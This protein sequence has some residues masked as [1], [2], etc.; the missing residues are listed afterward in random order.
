MSFDDLNILS[1]NEIIEFLKEANRF[2]SPSKNDIV[3]FKYR[4]TQDKL[5]SQYDKL[6]ALDTSQKL[7][8]N[9]DELAKKF[10][11]SEDS[12]QKLKLFNSRTEL[13]KKLKL[14][15]NEITAIE[16]KMQENQEWFEKN[17]C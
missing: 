1:K 5:L 11:E 14:E 7:A 17:S 13:I 4:K 6:L 3:Y 9:I 8:K 2:K 12:L 16:N 10:N 15:Q